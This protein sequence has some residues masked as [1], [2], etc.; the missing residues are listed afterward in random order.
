M[1]YILKLGVIGSWLI[2]ESHL[3]ALSKFDFVFTCIG[4]RKGSKR[5]LE[6]ASKYGFKKVYPDWKKVLE[7]DIEAVLIA[8]N[9]ETNIEALEV[10]KTSG[11][12]SNRK[13]CKSKCW[14]VEIV[15]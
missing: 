14:K 5:C 12:R 1:E 9:V 13:A 10:A 7:E 11:Y 3:D 8:A 2:V 15:K 6:V 4:T